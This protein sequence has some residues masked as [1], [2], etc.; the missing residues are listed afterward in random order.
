MRL[1]W[2]DEERSQ[3]D[4]AGRDIVLSSWG[5]PAAILIGLMA[6]SG[7]QV[8]MTD[9]PAPATPTLALDSIANRSVS[10]AD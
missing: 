6:W 1:M 5:I 9:A 10:N 2:D 4:R 8:L 3:E 7:V